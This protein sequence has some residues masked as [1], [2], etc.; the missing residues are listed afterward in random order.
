LLDNPSY[1]RTWYVD[2]AKKTVEELEAGTAKYVDFRTGDFAKRAVALFNTDLPKHYKKQSQR[3][4]D[5]LNNNTPIQI[6]TL[7]A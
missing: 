7:R 6:T 1:S 3:V 2:Q 4:I 5:M